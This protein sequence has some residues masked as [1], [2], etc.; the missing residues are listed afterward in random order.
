[1]EELNRQLTEID[2][3]RARLSALRPLPVEAL[4]KI[5]EAL[6][7]E[8]TYESNR[9]EGNTLTLQ[10]TAL[11]VS[12]G[13]SMNPSPSGDPWFDDPRNIAELSRRIKEY[14]AGESKF[15]TL[16]ELRKEWNDIE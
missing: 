5:E 14:E 4:K 7:I 6:A 2:A 15:V 12:E 10:E 13:I 1:M 8:Y 16:E 11:V 9:I 3:L